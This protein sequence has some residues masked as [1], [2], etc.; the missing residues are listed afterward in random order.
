M[1]LAADAE[2][3][4]ERLHEIG[5]RIEF[6][7]EPF[8]AR[9]YHKAAQSLRGIAEPL[10]T[11][12]KE[13]RL[14]ELPGVGE[15]LEEKIKTLAETG[16][17]PLL[18]RLREAIPPAA[19]EL[20]DVGGLS[21]EKA[22]LLFR[23]YHIGGLNDLKEAC[24]SG[25]IAGI[26]GFG[27]AL[28]AKILAGIEM[29]KVRRAYL[30]M[31]EAHT[32]A[33]LIL[34][35][36]GRERPDLRRVVPAGEVRRA[37][38]VAAKPLVFVAEGKQAQTLTSAD[39][40]G[41]RVEVTE[42][43]DYALALLY[44]TGSAAH[45]EALQARAEAKGLTLT[46][47][48]LKR[49]D[50]PV[51]LANEA[52]IYAALELPPLPPELREGRSELRLAEENRLP[53]LIEAGDIQG[54]LHCHTVASDGTAT[55][56][57][58]AEAARA[59]G[60][61]YFGVADHSR[62]AAYAG[63]LKEEAVYAQREEVERLNAEYAETEFRVFH[64]IECDILT[65]GS[66]DY[67]DALLD[68]FDYVVASVHSRFSLDREAQTERIVRAAGHPRTT[69]LGHLTGRLLLQREGYAVNVER[70]LEACAAGGVAVE[71]NAD[72]HRL[73]LDWRLH[74]KARELGC[75]FS[76]N[77]DAH[78]TGGIANVKWG[79]NA[80]R[81]GGVS[82]DEVLNCLSRRAFELYLT[83]RRD[84]GGM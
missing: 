29:L 74:E 21:T 12:L 65:D 2:T 70:V 6:E 13:G 32:E 39:P 51:S 20:L 3:V 38:E 36:L 8:K 31:D 24:E 73:D 35:T 14:R 64:G 76:I 17:H 72:A 23:Q 18:E 19:L 7:G 75:L 44:E 10:E 77:P 30:R 79:V 28:Q 69:L 1:K 16:T 67:P 46:R 60:Y 41:W 9:A 78:S 54:I 68:G 26:K 82:A 5:K 33:G 66:L 81:K 49:G 22:V 42:R 50:T 11:V 84:R 63:G 43:E 37:C 83:R 4:A 56:R 57:Q 80:A 59:L 62:S 40:S 45:L 27:A 53:V 61:G 34:Q 55:L 58:M 48:G 25:E 47:S 52:E 71:I 15:A